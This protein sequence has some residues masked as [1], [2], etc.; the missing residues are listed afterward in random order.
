MTARADIFD[1][2]DALA[3]GTRSRLL[4]VLEAHEMTVSELRSVLQLPQSTVSRHLKILADEGWVTSRP[5]GSSHRYRMAMHRFNPAARELWELVRAE[6]E[7]TTTA[8][9]DAARVRSV[10]EARRTKS[11]EFF[12][13]AAGQW[14]GLRRELFGSRPEL[15]ALPA[16]FAGHWTVGDLG[17]GTGQLAEAL[18]PFVAKIIAVDESPAMLK[19]A[20]GRLAHWDNVEF[21]R[22]ELEALPIDDQGLDVAILSLVLHYAADPERILAEARRALRV[23]GRLLIIDMMP[24]ERQEYQSE[25]GH[26]WQGFSEEQISAWLGRA[27]FDRLAYHTLPPDPEAKGPTLFAASACRS[28]AAPAA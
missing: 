17:S 15:S 18:A 9:H 4:L 19:A 2:M 27:G 1:R 3:D 23:G 28:D 11:R 16:L 24:H 21:R 25:M 7:Q 26:V 20:R 14:D 12:S 10:V 8:A 22:G 13:S 5:D 6:V